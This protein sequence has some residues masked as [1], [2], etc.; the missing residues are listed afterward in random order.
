MIICISGLSG[1]GKNS[2]GVEAAKLLD[3]RLVDPT[4]KTIAAKQKMSLMEFHKKAEKEHSIDRHFDAHLVAEAKKGNCGG[5]MIKKLLP[6][7]LKV[8]KTDAYNFTIN[9]NKN[10]GMCV[11]HLHIHIIPRYARDGFQH[12]SIIVCT[13]ERKEIS[14]EVARLRKIFKYK[15]K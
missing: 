6:M 9:A 12:K 1:S 10:A 5:I 2:V 3:L 15:P 11:P 14:P 4:F 7:L 8:Y 13:A